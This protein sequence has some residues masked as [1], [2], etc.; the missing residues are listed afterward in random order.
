MKKKYWNERCKS[1]KIVLN[2]SLCK[3]PC[4]FFSKSFDVPLMQYFFFASKSHKKVIHF[5]LLLNNLEKW[6][7]LMVYLRCSLLS[8]TFNFLQINMEEDN[9]NYWDENMMIPL[10]EDYEIIFRKQKNPWKEWGGKP[11]SF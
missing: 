4:H 5:A 9:K 6:Q 2:D 11:W 10:K 3:F 7:Q 1:Y 8:S